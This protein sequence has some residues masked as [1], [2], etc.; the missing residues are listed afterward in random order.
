MQ[1]AQFII[2]LLKAVFLGIVE[3]ITEW[4]PISSTGHLIL[5]NEFLNLRQSKDF[6]DMFNIV[7]QLG[8]ILAVMVIYFKRLNPFQP[9]K[10][11]REVQLTWQLWLKVVI[12]CIP[13][14]FFGLLLDAWMMAHQMDK[15]KFCRTDAF[16]FHCLHRKFPGFPRY[17]C[18]FPFCWIHFSVPPVH[19]RSVSNRCI[20]N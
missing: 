18:Y 1:T 9:G 4:L 3:G 10:T 17:F 6:I 12:A 8:A 15:V 16:F 19:S 2:E 20:Y 14:A 13:S 7:I 5:V 11:A